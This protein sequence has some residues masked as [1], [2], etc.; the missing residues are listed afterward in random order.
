MPKNWLLI[1]PYAHSLETGLIHGIY[2]DDVHADFRQ[3]AKSMADFLDGCD[4]GGLQFQPSTFLAEE[5]LRID[6]F[7]L[8]GAT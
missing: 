5:F 6:H 3:Y 2:D 4:L 1:D 8:R 7:D